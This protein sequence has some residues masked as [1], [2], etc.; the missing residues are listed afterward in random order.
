MPKLDGPEYSFGTIL[1]KGAKRCEG[2]TAA[3]FKSRINGPSTAAKK[4]NRGRY[5]TVSASL[6]YVDTDL[7][8]APEASVDRNR[9]FDPLFAHGRAS[10]RLMSAKYYPSSFPPMPVKLHQA[11]CQI[12][13]SGQ[14]LDKPERER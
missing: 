13:R 14:R 4:F 8:H 11:S 7:A 10:P 6:Q 1:E 12:R 2:T 3:D 5:R 9:D